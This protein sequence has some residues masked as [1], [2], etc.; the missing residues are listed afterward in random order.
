MGRQTSCGAL[1]SERPNAAV[2]QGP[3]SL[4]VRYTADGRGAGGMQVYLDAE[5]VILKRSVA[6]KVAMTVTLP[7]SAYRGVAVRLDP[8]AGGS[9]YVAEILLL[10]HDEALNLTLHRAETTD[11][12]VDIWQGWGDALGLPLMAF[13]GDGRVQTVILGDLLTSHAPL[14]RRKGSFFAGRRPRFLTRRKVGL[15]GRM[16]VHRGERE[17]I[18]RD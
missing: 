8:V 18:A 1:R 14:P 15:S 13:D 10:H 2:P 16:G 3:V 7:V 9:G 11:E 6:A 17:I 5:R 12:L 4:P